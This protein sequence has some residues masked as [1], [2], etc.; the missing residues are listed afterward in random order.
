METR[1]VVR[2]VVA[3]LVVAV[4]VAALLIQ[5]RSEERP[6]ADPGAQRTASPTP[7]PSPSAT[8]LTLPDLEG[9]PTEG[10]SVLIVVEDNACWRGFVGG[11]KI[12]ECGLERIDLTAVPNK[13]KAG[14]QLKKKTGGYRLEVYIVHE[15]EPVAFGEADVAGEL[16]EVRANLSG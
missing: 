15:G 8:E 6:A 12:E 13:I 4:A 5:T 7:T 3:A 1:S 16:V 2:W 11:T 10:T 14:A 9:L